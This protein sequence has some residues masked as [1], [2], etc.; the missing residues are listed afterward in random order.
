VVTDLQL[1]VK[2]AVSE[3]VNIDGPGIVDSA[4]P[5]S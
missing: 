3:A 1:E 4:A 2:A 5:S